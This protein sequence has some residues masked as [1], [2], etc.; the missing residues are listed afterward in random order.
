LRRVLAH[1]GGRDVDAV[2][3]EFE[4]TQA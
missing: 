1:Y 3:T 2:L 4:R